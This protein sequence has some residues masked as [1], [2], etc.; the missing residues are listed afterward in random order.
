MFT[1]RWISLTRGTWRQT[2]VLHRRDARHNRSTRR[3]G[4]LTRPDATQQG[5]CR[6]VASESDGKQWTTYR[7]LIHEQIR[8]AI[9]G[10]A[11]RADCPLYPVH[12]RILHSLPRL[13]FTVL[14]CFST[15]MQ[16]DSRLSDAC[17]DASRRHGSIQTFYSRMRICRKPNP[18]RT[19]ARHPW[20]HIAR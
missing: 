7:P 15:S 1:A 5:V 20:M 6:S 8:S 9:H 12:G 3:G 16:V 18:A 2:G 19:D 14:S 4:R 13:F 17:D 11:P 10:V